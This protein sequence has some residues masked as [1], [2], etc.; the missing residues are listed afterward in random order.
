MKRA[1]L[2][3]SFGTS[4]KE[5]RKKNIEAIENR[6]QEE[7]SDYVVYRAF[8]SKMIKQKLEK[9]GLLIFDIPQA[10]E[11]MKK[12]GVKEVLVQPTHIINGIEYDL[13]RE[14]IAPYLEQFQSILVGSP[15]LTKH[16]DY[17]E[18]ATIIKESYLVK[19]EEALV[20]MGHGSKHHANASYP[21]F[22]Y[23]L[24]D[25]GYENIFVGTVEGY[26]SLEEVKKQL[27]K[28]G[29]QKVCLAPM[30]IVAGDHANNDMIGDE[31]SWKCELEEAGYQVRYSLK[32]LGE[33][34]G[35]QEMFIRKAK[36]A[37]SIS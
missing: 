23:V 18:L 25:L 22:E 14:E 3:A 7:F 8:T 33:L 26:P 24:K 21:A 12:N 2:V 28:Q 9:E 4:Y 36:E 19:K 11:Q 32:G 31:D 13:L 20:L 15:L 27:E 16:E 30:M 6:L 35:V 34:E 1:L 10:L 37:E 5:T 29:Y 17:I